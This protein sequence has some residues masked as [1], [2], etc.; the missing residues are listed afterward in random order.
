MKKTS[1][2]KPVRR[3]VLATM[4]YPKASLPETPL[5]SFV[6]RNC[7]TGPQTLRGVS[8][9]YNLPIWHSFVEASSLRCSIHGHPCLKHRSSRSSFE[10]APQ[11]P[12]PTLFGWQAQRGISAICNSSFLCTSFTALKQYPL[13]YPDVGRYRKFTHLTWHKSIRFRRYWVWRDG[14]IF[15]IYK[16]Q[17]VDI[18]LETAWNVHH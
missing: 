5:E 14:S 12:N 2:H 13:F 8:A 6:I 3:S 15:F 7:S 4:K 18:R 16:A 11:A 17:V 1:F 10:I 9:L